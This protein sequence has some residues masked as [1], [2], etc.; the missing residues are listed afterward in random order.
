V[1]PDIKDMLKKKEIEQEK[2][3][4][5]EETRQSVKKIKRSDKEAFTKVSFTS[6]VQQH[7]GCF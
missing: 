5:E 3:R 6:T 2:E 4:I 1:L 7:I